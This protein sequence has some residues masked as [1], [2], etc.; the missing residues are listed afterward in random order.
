LLTAAT[1]AFVTWPP[2]A[3]GVRGLILQIQNAA[4]VEAAQALGASPWQIFRY[5]L[6]PALAPFAL[7]QTMVAAPVFVLGEVILSFLN[8]GFQ[9]SATS[10]G[11]ML[12]NLMR[13]PRVLTDFWWNLSP[14]GFVFITLFCLNSFSRRLRPKIPAQLA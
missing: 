10:W 7:A 4:Y 2:L 3:R 5:H 12:R 8:V 1:L 11:A 13:D 14:L 6:L 9:G